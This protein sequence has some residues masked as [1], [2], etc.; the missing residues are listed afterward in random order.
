MTCKCSDAVCKAW[1]PKIKSYIKNR[2]KKLNLRKVN[3]AEMARDL[4]TTRP[5]LYNHLPFIELCMGEVNIDRRRTD[6]SSKIDQLE[7]R[8]KKALSDLEA[9][10]SDLSSLR[11]SVSRIMRTL[12]MEKAPGVMRESW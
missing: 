1:H 2:S 8:L 7:I 9:V 3:L 5:T 6:G 11:A 10:S 4:S 12:V